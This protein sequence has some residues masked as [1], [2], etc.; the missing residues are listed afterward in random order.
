MTCDTRVI[1][2]CLN[3]AILVSD[4]SL[5]IVFANVAAETLL[6]MSRSR[7]YTLK[8]SDLID[9]QETL[10]LNALNETN[11]KPNFQGFTAT[12]ILLS[13]EPGRSLE[14]S[15]SIS[16][17]HARRSGLMVEITVQPHQMRLINEQQQR[18]QHSAARNLIRSLAH[19]I[20][21]P[22]GGIRGAAQLLEMSYKNIEGITDYTKV[23]IEQTDRLK[24]LVDRLLG[25]QRPNPLIPTN[26]HYVIEKVLSLISMQPLGDIRIEKDYDPSLP[27]ICMDIDAMQ[28]VLLNIVNNASQALTQAKTCYPLIRIQTRAAIHQIVNNVRY[29]TALIISISNNGPKIPEEMLSRIFYPMVTTKNDGNG[30]GLSIAQGIVERHGGALECKSDTNQTVFRIILPLS[31]GHKDRE[32]K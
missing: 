19:E 11:I 16:Y 10:L 8:F 22:L 6:G 12:G 20:K 3:T 24:E 1:V 4:T 5:K 15:L 31:M 30:L 25:P 13:P 32:D 14:A 29:S 17:Y 9:K 7:L 27:E 28:Q 21:N 23:I 18:E 2:E 26:I